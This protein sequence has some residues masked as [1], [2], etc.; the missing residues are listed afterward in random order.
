MT[1]R[2]GPD[3]PAGAERAR[4]RAVTRRPGYLLVALVGLL[5]M[6]GS[7]A[8][9]ANGRV[10]TAER[11]VFEAVNGLPDALRPPMWVLQLAGLIGLPL[12][13]ALV[14]LVLRRFRLALAA[15]ALVPLKLYLEKVVKHYVDRERP[16]RTEVDPILRGV[17]VSAES[18]PSGHAVVAFA[19]AVLLTPDLTP[20]WRFVVWAL[21]G[22]VAFSRVYLGAHN[23]L[24][25]IAGAGLGLF[26][27]GVLTFVVGVPGPRDRG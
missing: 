7:G 1:A 6:L 8:V 20:R 14:A 12:V 4:A 25:V 27:G 9:A 23:P 17:P 11:A 13:V 26:L 10:G 5:L 3:H 24:D 19:L 2:A 18:F 15:V 21:A 16:G 22:L